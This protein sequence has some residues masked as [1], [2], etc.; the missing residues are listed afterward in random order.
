VAAYPLVGADVVM[1][2]LS[3][4]RHGPRGR[5]ARGRAAWMERNGFAGVGEF[6]GMLAS[7]ADAAQAGYGRSGYLSAIARATRAYAPR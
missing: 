1:T 5:P 6:R 7:A 4:L 2:T 3:L